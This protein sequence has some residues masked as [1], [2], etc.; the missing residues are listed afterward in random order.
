MA[1]PSFYTGSI[2]SA[3]TNRET[4]C[5]ICQHTL[6]RPVELGCGNLVCLACI[7]RSLYSG[8]EGCPCCHVA[9]LQEHTTTPSKVTMAV[10][11]GQLV[12]C[13]KG[14]NRTVRADQYQQH[15]S[16]KCQEFYEHSTYSPS[17]TTL[18]DVLGKDTSTPTTHTE[19]RVA[20][21]LIKRLMA[22]SQD[23]A[24]LQVPTRGQ[25]CEVTFRV[26]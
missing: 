22:E 3:H 24:L 26:K 12:E 6:D 2:P 16:S 11:G 19:K 18:S 20:Q 4:Q 21:H 9:Q 17:R 13:P 25:V 14:C 15:L 8:C 5:T 23:K 1:P 10:L 7:T